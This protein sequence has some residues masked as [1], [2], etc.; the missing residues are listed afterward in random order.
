MNGFCRKLAFLSTIL[1]MSGCATDKNMPLAIQQD[2][3]AELAK[4]GP[5]YIVVE[6]PAS[7][8]D[9]VRISHLGVFFGALGAVADVGGA[10]TKGASIAQRLEITDPSMRVKEKFQDYLRTNFSAQ[11]IAGDMG[12]GPSDS[13]GARFTFATKLLGL[14]CYP[15]G[16]SRARVGYTVEATLYSNQS[17]SLLWRQSCKAFSPASEPF[18]TEQQLLDQ[19]GLLL[20][21]NLQA[22]ADHCADILL[23]TLSSHERGTP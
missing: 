22:V 16:C 19:D 14:F 1:V 3:F 15:D 4:T 17:G 12:G 10:N 2:K 7:F 8:E 11:P 21:K 20:K 5:I 6:K 13:T 9:R 18:Y 23:S